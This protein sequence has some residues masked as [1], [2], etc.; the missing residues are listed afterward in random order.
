MLSYSIFFEHSNKIL[1]ITE[2]LTNLTERWQKY[3][4]S[5]GDPKPP[6]PLLLH[7]FL[8][9]SPFHPRYPPFISF[10]PESLILSTQIKNY[11][12]QNNYRKQWLELYN[13]LVL[14]TPQLQ[15][16]LLL[17]T[18]FFVYVKIGLS[19]NLN[20]FSGWN[21]STCPDQ[22]TFHWSQPPFSPFLS[23]FPPP[24]LLLLLDSQ[25][26]LLSFSHFILLQWWSGGVWG[27]CY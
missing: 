2:K 7:I 12:L 13:Q 24:S 21:K 14:A 26:I 16:N 8:S 23:L 3:I 11:R 15:K 6:F 9:F 5:T 4:I 27:I 20:Q 22:I 19:F 10:H 17:W 1:Q 25:S 18:A